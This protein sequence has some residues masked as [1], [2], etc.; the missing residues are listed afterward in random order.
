MSNAK[1]TPGELTGKMQLWID[2]KKNW[3][4]SDQQAFEEISRRLNSHADLLEALR[5][6]CDNCA[7]LDPE[8]L[9]KFDR[10]YLAAR[11]AIAKAEGRE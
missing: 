1:H 6:I 3:R 4:D 7:S 11:A 8:H 5:A 2:R 10:Y 9:H